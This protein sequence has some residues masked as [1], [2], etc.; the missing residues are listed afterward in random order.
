MSSSERRELR[1]GLTGPGPLLVHRPSGDLF[2]ARVAHPPFLE[3]LLDVPVLTST[4]GSLLDT[5]RRHV[6]SFRLRSF[7]VSVRS[8]AK[9]CYPPRSAGK[10]AVVY[11]RRRSGRKDPVWPSMNPW[12]PGGI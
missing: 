3:T 2:G 10:R 5:R 9:Y 12:I 1:L 7:F 11:S 4:L 8:P 6:Y